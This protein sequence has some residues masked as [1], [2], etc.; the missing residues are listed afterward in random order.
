MVHTIQMIQ[1]DCDL[2]RKR[3]CSECPIARAI[4]RTLPQYPNVEVSG[5]EIILHR[6]DRKMIK[7]INLA[8]NIDYFIWNFD[9]GYCPE[10]I[11]FE[12]EIPQ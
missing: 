2:G 8:E 4:K 9:M 6:N 1:E 3:S 10:P 7:I 12:L 11:K 5:W